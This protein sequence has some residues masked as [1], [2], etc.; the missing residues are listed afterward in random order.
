[1]TSGLSAGGGGQRAFRSG[2]ARPSHD[3]QYRRADAVVHVIGLLAVLAGCVLLAVHAQG[4]PGWRIPIA[5]GLYALGMVATFGCSAA[6][7][8]SPPGP[9][10]A[11][12]RRLDHAAIF[13]MI[14]G[15]YTPVALLAIDGWQGMALFAFVWAGALL[16]AAMK[17][18][19]PGRFE[20]TAIA[21]YLFLGWVG[22]V[23]MVPLLQVLP[24]WQLGALL[25]GGILYS[26]GVIIHLSRR[27]PYNAAI[28]HALVLAAAC[29][30]YAVVL[31]IAA[32]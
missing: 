1:V 13:L 11:L 32:R 17:L 7:N 20:R 22:A 5:L 14:A 16:G 23:A 28:W 6:Y 10:R 31:G 4:L 24:P 9:R 18:V 25:L 29:C 2:I 12:L 26:L 30:H 15:T 8:M 21:A 19:A 27:L 3:I